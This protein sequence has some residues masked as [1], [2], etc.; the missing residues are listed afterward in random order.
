MDSLGSLATASLKNYAQQFWHACDFACDSRFESTHKHAEFRCVP[1]C[2]F[3]A[4]I[5]KETCEIGIVTELLSIFSPRVG[6]STSIQNIRSW[7][8]TNHALRLA[9]TSLLL[10]WQTV[11]VYCCCFEPLHVSDRRDRAAAAPVFKQIDSNFEG[12]GESLVM[13]QYLLVDPKRNCRRFL[14]DLDNLS[15]LAY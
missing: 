2:G 7:T 10:D 8:L 4:A 12:G 14:V 6:E 13:L 15:I 5:E 11:A 3:K 1:L 9:A